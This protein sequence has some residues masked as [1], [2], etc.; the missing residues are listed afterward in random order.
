MTALS[1]YKRLE[2]TA[3]WRP[4]KGQKRRDVVVSLGEASLTISDM[5]DAALAHWSLAA[6][7]RK[8]KS[9]PAIFAP[10]A[11]SDEEIEIADTDMLEAIKRIQNAY[12]RGSPR[13]GALRFLLRGGSV[14]LVV[15]MAVFWLPGA[16][17]RYTA[18]L[19]P[20]AT[21]AAIARDTLAEIENLAGRPCETTSGRRAK[22]TLAARLFSQD[23]KI[24]VLPAGVAK[25]A[26]LV[27]G[28]LI[29]GRSLV[30]DFET[31]E[32]LAGYLLAE[33]V[34]RT[35]TDPIERLLRRAGIS[36]SLRL[37]TTGE[38][39][40]S[41]LKAEAQS[42]IAAKAT[43]PNESLLLLAFKT[44]Q[45]ASA[46]YAYAEDVTGEATLALVEADIE[47]P[48]GAPLLSD[49]NWIALQS[50]CEQN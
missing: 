25:T 4:A 43:A 20:E 22:A 7:E 6:L 39:P 9:L 8:N 35:E 44:A 37:L 21:V 11:E 49:G 38:L 42:T 14:F 1:E 48:L 36:A 28:T 23:Q 30:E 46:P 50:I 3:I 47:R 13:P 15:A 12:S 26:H 2:A 10:G 19:V 32:P 31:P 29:V 17:A 34:R 16:L 27:D 33:T 40:E 24:I 41:A 5:S 45:V 18:N